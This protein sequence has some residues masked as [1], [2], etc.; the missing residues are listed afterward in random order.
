MNYYFL[1][2]HDNLY[3]WSYWTYKLANS[4]IT[5]FTTLVKNEWKIFHIRFKLTNNEEELWM[6]IKFAIQKLIFNLKIK[7]QTKKICFKKIF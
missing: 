5:N 6:N 2:L 3:N 4:K 7:I 1:E